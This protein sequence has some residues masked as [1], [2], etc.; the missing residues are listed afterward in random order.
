MRI[1]SGVG[2]GTV[3]ALLKNPQPA[4]KP[5]HDDEHSGD[6]AVAASFTATPR[7]ADGVSTKD[8]KTR[9]TR[10]QEGHEEKKNKR[11]FLREL[12]GFV[13]FVLY[14]ECVSA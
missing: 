8:T 3:V 13:S 10:R 6:R 5:D 2:P 11:A 7:R 1:M 4:K 12:R 9:R 14:R